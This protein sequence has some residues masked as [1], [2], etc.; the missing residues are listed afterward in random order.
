M[1][2]V[3]N[4]GLTGL[5]VVAFLAALALSGIVIVPLLERWL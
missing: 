3:A 1:E 5:G 4:G 2:L